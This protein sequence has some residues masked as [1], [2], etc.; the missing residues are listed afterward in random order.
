M[1][2]FDLE[3]Q[4]RV[5]ETFLRI[6]KYGDRSTVKSVTQKLIEDGQKR[7]AENAKKP[8]VE[9]IQM[10]GG[11]SNKLTEEQQEA[12]R[13]KNLFEI[14]N[15]EEIKKA[16]R[17]ANAAKNKAKKIQAAQDII[18]AEKAAFKAKIA[19]MAKAQI[20]ARENA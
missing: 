15:R 16:K 13:A 3:K 2:K 1:A 6:A 10:A 20:A 7:K 18:D 19:R 8:K 9:E 12:I 4:D 14:E 11:Y 5:S 17:K